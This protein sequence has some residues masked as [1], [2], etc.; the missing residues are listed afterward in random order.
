MSQEHVMYSVHGVSTEY[1]LAVVLV[2]FQNI[3]I[4]RG[5]SRLEDSA[6]S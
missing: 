2:Q 5:S 6:R 4:E 3:G 1:V